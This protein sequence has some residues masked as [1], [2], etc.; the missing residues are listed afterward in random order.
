MKI[1][2]GKTGAIPLNYSA[3]EI[4]LKKATLIFLT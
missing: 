3:D 2:K 4:Y 1:I